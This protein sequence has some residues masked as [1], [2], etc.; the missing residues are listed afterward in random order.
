VSLH[1]QLGSKPAI[2]LFFETL[3]GDGG[4][5]ALFHC[6]IGRDR[7]TAAGGIEA[8]LLSAGLDAATLDAAREALLEPSGVMP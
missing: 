8:Y 1:P 6:V 2:K 4:T 7:V 3:T 5:P